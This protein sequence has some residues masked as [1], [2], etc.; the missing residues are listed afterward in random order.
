MRKWSFT[1]IMILAALI[2]AFL[3]SKSG[4]LKTMTPPELVASLEITDVGTK[5]TSK[6]YQPWPPKLVLVPALSFRVRNLTDKPLKYINFNANFRTK[7]DLENMGD[8]FLAAIRGNPIPPGELSETIILTS[9]YG[10]E[11]RTLA[12]FKDN[13][14][15]KPVIVTVYAQSKGSQLVKIGEWEI[16]R[17]IDFQEPE[18]VGMGKTEE[19]KKKE[20]K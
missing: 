16:S 4:L 6:Y 17:T 14:Q 12:S 1:L 20:K 10:V 7:E 15:W 2:L 13:P 5:W 11:G 18:P 9:N 3:L 8:S 19:K